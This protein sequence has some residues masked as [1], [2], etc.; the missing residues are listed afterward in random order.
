[1]DENYEEQRDLIWMAVEGLCRVFEMQVRSSSVACVIAT[2]A[3]FQ[4]TTPR[5]D[6]CRMLAAEGLLTPL[7]DALIASAEDGDELAESAKA[8]ICSIFL[9]F[10]QS[11]LKVKEALATRPVITRK[12][13]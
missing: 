5:T 8:K 4:G 10:A 6:F 12:S 9:I 2:M 1:M 11:D 7:A 13:G 3:I